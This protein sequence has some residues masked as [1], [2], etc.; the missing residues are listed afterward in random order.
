[1]SNVDPVPRWR[2]DTADEM[3]RVRGRVLIGNNRGVAGDGEAVLVL[4]VRCE[5]AMLRP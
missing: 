2:F 3:V 4:E 1:M 5:G